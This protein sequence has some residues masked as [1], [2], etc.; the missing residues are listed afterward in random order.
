MLLR[1]GQHANET[2]IRFPGREQ[3][4]VQYISPPEQQMSMALSDE[5]S[6]L[7]ISLEPSVST[8]DIKSKHP[9][10]ETRVILMKQRPIILKLF[11][12]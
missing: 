7:K 9:S 4:E 11:H 5:V 3:T 12:R 6:H 8:V 2:K 10:Y 1:L